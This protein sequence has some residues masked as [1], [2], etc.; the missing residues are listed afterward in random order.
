VQ[1]ET[2]KLIGK[3]NTLLMAQEK[4]KKRSGGKGERGE[5]S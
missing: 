3:R 2:P 4:K 5:E 1:K